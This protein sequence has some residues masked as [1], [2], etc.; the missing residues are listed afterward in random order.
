[1]IPTLSASV[2]R[3]IRN[4]A[5]TEAF[6]HMRFGTAANHPIVETPTDDIVSNWF[7]FLHA[8]LWIAELQECPSSPASFPLSM[9][10]HTDSKLR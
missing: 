5:Y 9:L 2:D 6:N 4:A 10:D 7:M 8:L 1:M 3:Y